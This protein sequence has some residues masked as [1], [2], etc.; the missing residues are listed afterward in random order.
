MIAEPREG[1]P[2]RI[3][4]LFP[5]LLGVGGIQE[6]GR[7]TAIALQKIASKRGW[8]TEFLALNDPR[9][10]HVF[11]LSEMEMPFRGFSRSKLGFTRAAMQMAGGETRI[12]L[13]THPHL[14]VPGAQMKLLN[15]HLK[16]LTISHGI[17]IWEPLTW[18]RRVAF[19]KSDV[20]LAPSRYTAEKIER[21]QNAPRN[22][23]RRLPWPLSPEIARMAERADQLP[24]P[25]AFPEGL[26]VLTVAR[27]AASEKYKGVDKLIQAIA[28]LGSDI[29][30]LHLVIV[31][32]GD[33]L[34]RHVRLAADLGVADCVHFFDN[35]ARDETAGCYFRSD[36][37][38]LPSSGEGFGL[39][40]LE[41]MAFGKPVIGAAAGGIP[42][43][44]E[45][46]T[47]GFLVSAGD[48]SQLCQALTVLLT[49]Q[50]LRTE[51]GGRGAE[52]VRTRYGFESFRAELESILGDC[53][54]ESDAR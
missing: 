20:F 23:V 11:R 47:N 28:H 1:P 50:Q 33:D 49:N 26:I 27:L 36:V 10:Y 39:V 32:G 14:A 21:E 19:R 37:F 7:L 31:G 53:G 54:L 40:F 29:E 44:V 6:A 46:G 30:N 22:R 4:G 43:I 41:A 16:M 13:V 42:D 48:V 18:F 35:L 8:S 51:L 34:A 17:E 52:L 12:V 2:R 38:A 5:E 9:G 45:D 25:A 24:V 3:V 15:G